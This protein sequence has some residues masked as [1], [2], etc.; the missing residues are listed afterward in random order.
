MKTKLLILVLLFA[1]LNANATVYYV[2]KDATGTNNG[3]NWTNAFTTIELAFSNAIV[4]DQ[5]WVAVGVYKPVGTTRSATFTIPNG[6]EVYGGF[7]GN[8]TLLSQRDL[9]LNL[10]TL[11]GD[12]GATG[13]QTDNCYSVVTFNNASNLTRFDGFK[14]INAYNNI[15]ST[16]GGAIR[17]ISG[18]PTISNCE[19]LA[20][21]A[22][23]GAAVGSVSGNG[24][25]TMTLISCKMRSNNALY[26]G[27]V[28]VSSGTVKLINCELF[29]NTA[30][31][32]GAI[33]SENGTLF[34]DR[35]KIS[36]NSAT[37]TGGAIRLNNSDAKLEM[38]N[39]LLVGN[40][41]DEGA[42]LSLAPISNQKIQKII[43]CTIS[44][45]RNISTS[46]STSTL[47]V[48]P[49][50]NNSIIANSIIWDNVCYRQ[51]LNGNAS[52]CIILGN[53]LPNNATNILTTN[54]NLTSAG[55]A[56]NAPFTHAAY[57]YKVSSTSTAINAGN[58]SFVNSLY[59]LD[60]D[61]TTR[62]QNTTVDIGCYET[63][64]NLSV[65]DFATKVIS[66][67]P[68]PVSNIITITATK[69]FDSTT[70]YYIF[71]SSG[72]MIKLGLLNN[73]N[74]INVEDI[75]QG[76]YILKINGVDK[77]IKFSKK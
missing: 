61:A 76:I 75:T 15:S 45:N 37:N 7:V 2:N 65:D 63:T 26:G 77:G 42:V 50:A 34:I 53:Y 68:N 44:G 66:I 12:I 41:A 55:D 60:L 14:I 18:E 59:N 36:G 33:Q 39:S 16:N 69:E 35:C 31:Y 23:N 49:S 11:N 27:A 54:P 40:L 64:T 51:L 28:F 47:I 1:F 21:Y 30:S 17:N 52:N 67:V 72:R 74:T 20:N 62:I 8:E 38:Y 56:N 13:I 3:T 10:T 43:N 48:L 25:Q 71:D 70:K 22:F 5:V 32:G 73:L 4:G 29:S 6:V 24:S 57:N 58:N 46:T 9:T 19:F